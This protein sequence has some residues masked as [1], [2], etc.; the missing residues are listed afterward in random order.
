MRWLSPAS[1]GGCDPAPHQLQRRSH[2]QRHGPLRRGPDNPTG[3]CSQLV[4]GIMPHRGRH[5]RHRRP[6][7]RPC[8]RTQAELLA[9]IPRQSSTRTGADRWPTTR[10]PATSMCL[11]LSVG[12]ST[13]CAATTRSPAASAT[14]STPTW[15]P[16]SPA[17]PPPRSTYGV[18]LHRQ[19]GER[20]RRQPGQALQRVPGHERVQGK[21]LRPVRRR[22]GGQRAG[23]G[24]AGGHLRGQD[25]PRRAAERV[26]MGTSPARSPR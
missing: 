18:R 22:T 13:T 17:T 1:S 16:I 10:S 20:R 12:R 3:D 26:P 2:A 14:A 4:H 11:R 8:P 15:R 7:R 19:H 23:A 6:Q 21:H 24:V 5:Q 25:L 9:A